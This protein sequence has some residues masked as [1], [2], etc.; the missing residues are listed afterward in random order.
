MALE[1]VDTFSVQDPT[2]RGV[3][4]CFFLSV[5]TQPLP[6]PLMMSLFAPILSPCRSF[7]PLSS[8]FLELLHYGRGVRDEELNVER[9]V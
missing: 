9:V 8:L 6:P 1:A 4:D 5:S 3:S 2:A 7:F